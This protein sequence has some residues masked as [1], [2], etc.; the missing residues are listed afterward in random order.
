MT[1]TDLTHAVTEVVPL[2][3]SAKSSSAG[4]SASSMSSG[5]DAQAE[6]KR[7]TDILRDWRG[8]QGLRD[9][10][11]IEWPGAAAID[12][13]QALAA[14]LQTQGLR[15]PTRCVPNGEGGIV[16]EYQHERQLQTVEIESVGTVEICRFSD[17][18][19]TDRRQIPAPA[20][21]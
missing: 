19:L 16:F 15:A 18:K 17:A 10:D 4:A 2:C 7:V 21:G 1:M 12:L 13:G 14:S 11:D 9:E 20:L 5:S 6:W 3:L 8:K